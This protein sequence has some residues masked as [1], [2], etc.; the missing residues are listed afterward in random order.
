M[1]Y[2]KIFAS[3]FVGLCVLILSGCNN[4]DSKYSMV[5]GTITYN[6]EA[7]AEATVSFQPVSPDGESASGVTDATGRFTLT[8]VGAT[9]GGRGALPGEYRV[10]I[11]KWEATPPD[12]D[13]EAYSQGQITYEQL[14]AR[15]SA[16]ATR[17]SSSV[18]TRSLIPERYRT[19]SGSGL[20]A[21][22]TTG[23]NTP[24]NFELTDD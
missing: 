20:T 22:V 17:G 23:R 19:A 6:G 8:S 13:E 12:P 15:L 5:E 1:Q 3:I 16:R 21:T 10:T 18:T 2:N 11:T 4:P 14:Q 7:V 24:F 9:T